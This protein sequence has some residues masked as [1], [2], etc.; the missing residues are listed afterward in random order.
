MDGSFGPNFA[1]WLSRSDPTSGSPVRGYTF[2]MRGRLCI[3]LSAIALSLAACNPS[4]R[5]TY[6]ETRVRSPDGTRDAVFADDLSGGP[7]TGTSQEVYITP[8]TK[9]PRLIDRVFSNECVH[10]VHLHWSDPRSLEVS[11]S[12]GEDIHEVASRATPSVW[13]APWLW[14]SSPS[15]SVSLH[16][17]RTILPAGNGC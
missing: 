7:A 11:Y 12:V 3:L 15:P 4:P 10:D 6:I 9:F 1:V 8:P 17:R 13:W 16:L 5:H 14:G 2:M